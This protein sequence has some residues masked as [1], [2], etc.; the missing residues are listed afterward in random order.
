MNTQAKQPTNNSF[1][2]LRPL[3]KLAAQP[4]TV[5]AKEPGSGCRPIG[6]T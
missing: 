1:K 4:S 2:L 5:L 3:K 6:E